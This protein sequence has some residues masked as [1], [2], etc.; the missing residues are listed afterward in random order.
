MIGRALPLVVAALLPFAA[1][2]AQEMDPASELAGRTPGPPS[3]CVEEDRVGSPLVFRP[4]AV[5]FRQSGRRV[6]RM[7]PIGSCT[8]LRWGVRLAFDNVGRRLCRGDR[9]A[10]FPP[11]STIPS[12]HCRIGSFVPY[13]KVRA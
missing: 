7:Q 9:F 4:D 8:Q 12:A 3:T 13:D 10:V 2:G 6:W 1:A 5:L 11:G